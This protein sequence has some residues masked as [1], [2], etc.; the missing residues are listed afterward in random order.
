[1]LTSSFIHVRGIGAITEQRIWR[2]GVRDWDTFLGNPAK[3]GFRGRRTV[4]LVESIALSREHLRRGNHRYFSELLA[5]R[6]HWR[7]FP[8]FNHRIAYL[9][10]ET[11]GTGED[12]AIT[13]VG[14]FDGARTHTY[15]KGE[16]LQD[17][18]EDVNRY[19][20]LVTYYG[21]GFDLP[22]LRR[23]FPHVRFDQLHIDLCT[24][25]HRLGYKGGLKR[26]EEQ[27]GIPRSAETA[28]LS[29]WD[30]V[31]MW[32]EW[33]R[34]SRES[35]ELLIRYNTEDI[36][37]LKALLEFAYPKLRGHVGFPEE[38]NP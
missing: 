27:L 34:G 26:I 12:D 35:L 22:F 17:F 33:V 6:E 32:R 16:N 37:H 20:L 38:G 18:A 2:R 4:S 5:P 8:E 14:V 19:Q 1:M 9:D 3:A 13:L 36:V 31:R 24:A 23:R 7:T 21:A 11:T 10:I 30:A 29:G 15:V 25:F 28:G